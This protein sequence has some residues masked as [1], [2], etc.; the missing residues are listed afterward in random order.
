M[1]TKHAIHLDCFKLTPL[2]ISHFT[3]NEKCTRTYQHLTQLNYTFLQKLKYMAH[4]NFT[5]S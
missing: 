3:L 5:F 2:Y 4:Y 1:A